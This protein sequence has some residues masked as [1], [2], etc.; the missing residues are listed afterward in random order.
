MLEKIA[1]NRNLVKTWCSASKRR[2]TFN[3]EIAMT[4]AGHRTKNLNE[5]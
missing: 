4:V 1:S 2:T 3:L 5:Q